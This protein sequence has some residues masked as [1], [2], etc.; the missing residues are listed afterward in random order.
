MRA[1]GAQGLVE[2]MKIPWLTVS[3]LRIR[4]NLGYRSGLVF[5]LVARHDFIIN[6][7]W[8]GSR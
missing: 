1:R 6:L 4:I 2:S 5:G 7:T 3:T 8:A